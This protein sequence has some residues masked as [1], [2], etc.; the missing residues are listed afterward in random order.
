MRTSLASSSGFIRITEYC[1]IHNLAI[2]RQ[3]LPSEMALKVTSLFLAIAANFD[4]VAILCHKKNCN[5]ML[6]SW[7]SEFRDRVHIFDGARIDAMFQPQF[8][9]RSKGGPGGRVKNDGH[10]FFVTMSHI[11]VANT[12]FKSNETNSFLFL[13]EDYEVV[14]PVQPKNHLK[15]SISRSDSASNIA[16]FVERDISWQFLRLGYNP[17]WRAEAI[18]LRCKPACI[19]QT[20]YAGICAIMSRN[21]ANESCWIGSTV[22]YAVHRRAWAALQELGYDALNSGS[23]KFKFSIDTW[24]PGSTDFYEHKLSGPVHYAIPGVLRQRGRKEHSQA[25]EAFSSKCVTSYNHSYIIEDPR[26]LG[27]YP[28]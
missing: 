5:T 8:G 23:D 6:G 16:R 12:L 17:R 9:K 18:T 3:A 19:C 28:L 15:L 21:F 20:I 11:H 22:G 7:P 4:R 27:N 2:L 26:L 13:E 10:G 14:Q 24:I 25:M 1:F